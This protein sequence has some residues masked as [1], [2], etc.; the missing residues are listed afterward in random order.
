M[1][2]SRQIISPQHLVILGYS[3]NSKYAGQCNL[4]INSLKALELRRNNDN[5]IKRCGWDSGKFGIRNEIT[6]IIKK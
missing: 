2:G 1:R 6:I 3:S 5:E 4:A